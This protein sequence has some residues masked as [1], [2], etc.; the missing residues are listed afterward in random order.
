MVMLSTFPHK[1]FWMAWRF[2]LRRAHNNLLALAIPGDAAP[3]S[4]PAERELARPETLS[5]SPQPPPTVASQKKGLLHSLKGRAKS[6]EP[7]ERKGV[8]KERV[9]EQEARLL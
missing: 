3:T 6:S 1:S 2:S 9:Q 4:G 5:S 7:G 8:W